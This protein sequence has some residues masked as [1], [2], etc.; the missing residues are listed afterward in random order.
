[1]NKITPVFTTIPSTP[2]IDN[3][4]KNAWIRSSGY[5]Y[6]DFDKAVGADIDRNWYSG[7]NAGNHPTEAGAKAL[8]ARF[9]LDFPEITI[10]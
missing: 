3:S 9:I 5:R 7:M 1:M 4:K 8:F 6:I 2:T 10:A